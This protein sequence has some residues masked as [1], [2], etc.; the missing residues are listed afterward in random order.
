[1]KAKEKWWVIL[2]GKKKKLLKPIQKIAILFQ[3]FCSQVV[4]MEG[5]LTRK[6][7][8]WIVSASVIHYNPR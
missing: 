8:R 1:M 2:S 5:M 7:P 3:R 4:R 6:H